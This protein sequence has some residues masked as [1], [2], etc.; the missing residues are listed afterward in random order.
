[1]NFTTF[2]K[3][4]QYNNT[5]SAIVSC[6][7]WKKCNKEQGT[8]YNLILSINLLIASYHYIFEYFLPSKGFNIAPLDYR[9]I[10]RTK[11]NSG[12]YAVV[13]GIEIVNPMKLK[14]DESTWKIQ[15]NKSKHINTFCNEINAEFM[16]GIIE[17]NSNRSIY[18]TVFA[19]HYSRSSLDFVALNQYS[20]II[21]NT[22]KNG[23]AMEWQGSPLNACYRASNVIQDNDIITV[24]LITYNGA[25]WVTFN[26]NST[27]ISGRAN[28]DYSKK[29]LMFV[30]CKYH[31]G[32]ATILSFQQQ[33]RKKTALSAFDWES[34]IWDG[35]D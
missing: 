16:I 18:D 34:E 25:S 31:S 10:Q 15:I 28:I 13:T 35:F 27:V 8:K 4:S 11:E 6:G 17:Y 5:I 21:I 12:I 24:K 3:L 9:K 22:T 23:K 32:R 20:K 29:Y 33:L 7:F 26:K 14:N 2:S 19:N 1:M 30:S